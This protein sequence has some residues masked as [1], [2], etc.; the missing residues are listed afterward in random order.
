MSTGDDVF[1][2]YV[3]LCT[4]HTVNDG[5]VDLIGK[6]EC[7]FL[8]CVGRQDTRLSLSSLSRSTG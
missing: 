1:H 5:H 3:N 6:Q 7:E 4:V 2:C 8:S